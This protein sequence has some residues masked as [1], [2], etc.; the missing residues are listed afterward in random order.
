M[1]EIYAEARSSSV[2][3]LRI[4]TFSYWDQPSVSSEIAEACAR[5]DL[6]I[7]LGGVNLDTLASVLDPRQAALCVLGPK[8]EQQVPMPFRP[9]HANGFQ[10]RGWSIA[11]LSGAPRIR[12]GIPGNYITEGEAEYL[13]SGLLERN[14]DIFLSHS[15]PANYLQ[16]SNLA[17]EVGFDALSSFLREKKILYHF[18]AHPS[19]TVVETPEVS[20][21]LQYTAEIGVCGYFGPPEMPELEFI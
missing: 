11:G 9:L 6:V 20:P 5:S 14:I 16:A 4:A 12:A 19:E 17:P 13:L 8:D 2:A 15:P 10:F 1:Q 18:Y 3:P 21:V 7:A